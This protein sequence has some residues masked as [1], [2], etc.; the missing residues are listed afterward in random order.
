MA[1]L[2]KAHSGRGRQYGLMLILAFGAAILGVMAIHKLRERR[3]LNLLVKEKDSE[4]FSLQ[5]LLKKEREEKKEAE[6]KTEEMRE[7]LFS[8]ETENRE[9]DSK[10][11]EMQSTI[12]SLQDE[13][14]TI[15]STLEEKQNEIKTLRAKEVETDRENARVVALTET[16]RQ[17]EDEIQDLKNRLENSNQVLPVSTDDPSKQAVTFSKTDALSEEHEASVVKQE[18]GDERTRG[19]GES[20]NESIE[21]D[22]SRSGEGRGEEGRG[23]SDT[24]ET[25]GGHSQNSADDFQGQKFSDTNE[26]T[27]EH[28][29]NNTDE[30][31]G[32]KISDPKEMTGEYSEDSTDEVRREKIKD[33]QDSGLQE[34]KTNANKTETMA[35]QGDKLRTQDE[36]T[37]NGTTEGKANGIGDV[38][39]VENV[40]SQGDT[41]QQLGTNATGE[42]KLE[43]AD[44][45]QDGAGDG[46]GA[47]HGNRYKE[48]RD[49]E[50]Q[51]LDTRG[52]N[53]DTD[54]KVK[55]ESGQESENIEVDGNHR[56]GESMEV[57]NEDGVR[58]NGGEGNN[59]GEDVEKAVVFADE[60]GKGGNNDINQQ[61]EKVQE[62]EYENFEKPADK[63]KSDEIQQ[64][65]GGSDSAVQQKTETRDGD[66]ADHNSE[67]AEALEVAEK[68]QDA[69]TDHFRESRDE[70][71]EDNE[72][73]EETD[74]L[75]F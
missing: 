39:E 50:L 5:L 47:K 52:N 1:G 43:M 75:E 67:E 24:N 17:K 68:I 22:T 6:R 4:L 16:L 44:N 26:I 25:T 64:Q 55:D 46:V 56:Q 71:D 12:S 72:S 38:A 51:K 62:G 31:Q 60:S 40:S 70:A 35:N 49:A 3:I 30:V 69:E 11:L 74:E 14:R 36:S 9:L 48:L 2:M 32:Q 45:S 42:M 65:S 54:L 63:Q 15:G 34:D 41:S 27:E 61:I 33:L 73:E 10:I 8:L 18:S 28:L 66:K 7:K 59:T 13:Q 21:G 23:L 29:Q 57:K 58:L 37:D 53:Q 19:A 20:L